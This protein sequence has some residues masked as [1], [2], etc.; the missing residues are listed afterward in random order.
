MVMAAPGNS[1]ISSSTRCPQPGAKAGRALDRPDGA[2]FYGLNHPYGVA[3]DA[4]GNVY[5]TDTG[6]N[7]VLKL[8]AQ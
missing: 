2:A 3:G 6:N 4:A 7:R 1:A 5:V 8:P